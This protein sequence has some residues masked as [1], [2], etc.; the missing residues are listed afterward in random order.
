MAVVD[1]EQHKI[2][3]QVAVVGGVSR[4]FVDLLNLN[5]RRYELGEVRGYKPR[6]VFEV[7]PDDPWAGDGKEGVALEALVPY[8][9]ALV[10][11]DDF[12]AGT[13]YSS[14]GIERLAAVLAP[15]KLH[16]PTG[17]FGGP[18]L[19]QEWQSLSGLPA[20]HVAD[21]RSDDALAVV[22]A[23]ARTLLRS[24]LRSTPPPPKVH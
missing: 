24:N 20:V 1:E 5:D 4:R 18:A 11:T 17:V 16:V 7:F 22:K 19:A 10:L 6:L 14:T 23:L 12:D 13:H 15:R 3:Y 2:A 21:P 9:D 8:L